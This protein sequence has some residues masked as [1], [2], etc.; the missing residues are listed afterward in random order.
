MDKGGRFAF[1]LGPGGMPCPPLE[2]Y[3]TDDEDSEEI[4]IPQ[5]GKQPQIHRMVAL[6][7][8]KPMVE[9]WEIPVEYVKANAA[10][11]AGLLRSHLKRKA[12]ELE[13]IRDEDGGANKRAAH[14]SS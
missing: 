6:E 4:A 2:A 14:A 8:G 3:Y 1:D 10:T 9:R 13:A 7:D 5:R 12:D 11:R